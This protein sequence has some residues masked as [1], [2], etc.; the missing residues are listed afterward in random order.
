V[1]ATATWSF[2]SCPETCAPT[3]TVLLGC[4]VP[5]D[6]TAFSTSPIV[7]VLTSGLS[8]LTSCEARY[9]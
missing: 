7:A 4:K 9:Q 8:P 2:C 5:D 6:A 1:I 3:G